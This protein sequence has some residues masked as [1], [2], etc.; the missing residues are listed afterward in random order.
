MVGSGSE[1]KSLKKHKHK[2]LSILELGTFEN[3]YMTKLVNILFL[4]THPERFTTAGISHA[5][6][7]TYIPHLSEVLRK[8]RQS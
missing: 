4:K 6:H 3:Y 1:A 7:H 8:S 2:K 5:P